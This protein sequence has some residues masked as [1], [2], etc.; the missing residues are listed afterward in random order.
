MMRMVLQRP[1]RSWVYCSRKKK[2]GE[3]LKVE[4]MVSL[5]RHHHH[6]HLLLCIVV[7][8]DSCAPAA[9]TF[10]T[11]KT[12]ATG[13]TTLTLIRMSVHELAVIEHGSHSPSSSSFIALLH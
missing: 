13:I 7:D 9:T 10:T 11:I 12:A 1:L 2:R 3:K 8:C 5:K 6:H 4:I